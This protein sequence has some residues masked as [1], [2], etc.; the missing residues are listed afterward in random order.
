MKNSIKPN[1]QGN[2]LADFLLQLIGRYDILLLC[3]GKQ[4]KFLYEP[5]AVKRETVA[6]CSIAADGGQ[7]IEEIP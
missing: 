3:S 2:P 1:P 6:S 7:A 5:V 4:V